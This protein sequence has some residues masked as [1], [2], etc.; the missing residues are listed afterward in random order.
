MADVFATVDGMDPASIQMLKEI[1]GIKSASGKMARDVRLISERQ[2]ELVTVH[3]LSFDADNELN[4]PLLSAPASGKN[5]LFLGTRMQQIYQYKRG[6]TLR[7][8]FGK[9]SSAFTFAGTVTQPDYIYAVPPSGSMVPDGAVY[10][11]AA[12]SL[13]TMRT[14]FGTSNLTELSFQLERGYRYEDVSHALE[15]CL[16]PFGLQQICSREKQ[17]SSNMVEGELKELM[18][19]GTVL[20]FLFLSVSVFILYVVLKKSA[21]RDRVL[22]GTMKA[23]GFHTAELLFPYWIQALIIGT[24]GAFLG[25]FFAGRFGRYMFRMYCDYFNLPNTNYRDFLMPRAL[26]VF[27]SASV[28]LF[29]VSSAVFQIVSIPPAEAMKKRSAKQVRKVTFSSFFMKKLSFWDRFTIRSMLRNPFR[30]FLIALSVAFPFALS[31]VCFSYGS[32]LDKI[33]KEQFTDLRP[34]D[35]EI[36]LAQPDSPYRIEDA[37]NAFSLVHKAEAVCQLPVVLKNNA[38]ISYN[39]LTGIRTNSTLWHIADQDGTF[40]NP[41][42]DGLIL[43][44]RIAKKLDLHTGDTVFLRIPG[45]HAKELPTKVSEIIS[46]TFGDG[47]YVGLEAFQDVLFF[48]PVANKA[49]LKALPGQVFA[50]KRELLQAD[51]ITWISDMPKIRKSYEDMMGSVSLMINAFAFMSI[52]A[53]GILISTISLIQIRERKTEF[54]TLCLLGTSEKEIRKMLFKEHFFLF[55]SGIFMGIPGNYGIR[56]LLQRFMKTDSYEFL[57]PFDFFAA[58]RALSFCMVI[59]FVALYK[60]MRWIKTISLTDALKERE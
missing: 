48:P 14:L 54:A 9:K 49:I 19:T 55:L 3:L 53:G 16:H 50:L 44:R 1:P 35:I 33:L 12:M 42:E 34:F 15:E 41:P 6:D 45:I 47:C 25:A 2:D 59:F 17:F 24:T 10:D 11:I 4:K 60:D 46:E 56:M 36:Q 51:Q 18:A 38:K 26:A 37:C 40:F 58:L 30:A 29:A 23:L 28:S 8:S 22:M 43:N 57:L 32:V 13:E 52:F 20:P 27:L 39:M 21:E 7:L 5:E 31:S